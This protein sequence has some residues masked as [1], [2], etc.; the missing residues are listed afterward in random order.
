MKE[1]KMKKR[2]M[3]WPLISVESSHEETSQSEKNP[4]TSGG[5]TRRHSPNSELRLDQ[6]G[7]NADFDVSLSSTNNTIGVTYTPSFSLI[8]TGVGL[9]EFNIFGC[10]F[11]AVLA[12]TATTTATNGNRNKNIFKSDPSCEHNII[13]TPHLTSP[14][15]APRIDTNDRNYRIGASDVGFGEFGNIRCIFSSNMDGI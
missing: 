7:L 10:K 9:A 5:E 4:P 6:S 12:L 14:S 8:P 13:I 2:E 1:R 15:T 3:K 11:N